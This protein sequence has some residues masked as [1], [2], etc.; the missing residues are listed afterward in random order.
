MGVNIVIAVNKLS[1]KIA[2]ALIMAHIILGGFLPSGMGDARAL[3][4]SGFCVITK[5][6]D[7]SMRSGINRSALLKNPLPCMSRSRMFSK[8]VRSSVSNSVWAID[9]ILRWMA[10][11]PPRYEK[12]QPAGF[13]IFVGFRKRT[14]VADGP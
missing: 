4:F 6:N 14:R 1:R 5:G 12:C 3:N 10:S 13:R 9:F 8:E 2:L 7:L 11:T